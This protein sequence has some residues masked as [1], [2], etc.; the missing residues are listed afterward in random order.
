MD[1]IEKCSTLF[2]LDD[3]QSFE[4]LSLALQSS[5]EIK[6]DCTKIKPIPEPIFKLLALIISGEIK[7]LS[8]NECDKRIIGKESNIH[9]TRTLGFYN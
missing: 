3:A 4:L 6:I 1:F 7:K 2:K 9:I 8:E 5:K